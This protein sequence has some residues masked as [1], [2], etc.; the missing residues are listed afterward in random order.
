MTKV[1]TITHTSCDECYWKDACV[2]VHIKPPR[3]CR[4]FIQHKP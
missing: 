3:F 2:T 4:N 1:D